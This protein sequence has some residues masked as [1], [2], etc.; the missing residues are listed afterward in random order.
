MKKTIQELEQYKKWNAKHILYKIRTGK[1]RKQKKIDVDYVTEQLQYHM[2]QIHPNPEED[3]V[4]LSKYTPTQSNLSSEVSQCAYRVADLTPYKLYRLCNAGKHIDIYATNYNLK[5]NYRRTS[6]QV[7]SADCLAMDIDYY[8]IP[9][10]RG[11][12]ASDV[13]DSIVNEVLLP[14]GIIPAYGIDSGQGLYIIILLEH[15]NLY[16]NTQNRTMFYFVMNKLLERLNKYGADKSCN[17]IARVF[18][19][20]LTRNSKTCRIAEI[21]N[22]QEISVKE[23]KR[24]DITELYHIFDDNGPIIHSKKKKPDKIKPHNSSSSKFTL[25]SL[26]QA[27][28]NDLLKLLYMRNRCMEHK[29]NIFLFYYALARAEFFTGTISDL[30]KEVLTVNQQLQYPLKSNEVNSTVKS[31]FD[32]VYNRQTHNGKKFYYYSNSDIIKHLEI[33][34]LECHD[35]KTLITPNLKQKRHNENRKKKRRDAAGKTS[36]QRQFEQRLNDIKLLYGQGLTQ[37]EIAHK[38]NVSASLVCQYLKKLNE[39]VS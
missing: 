24:Y 34:D 8:T 12:K 3:V 28:A 14:L 6:S 13:Y 18:R 35:M 29:R 17:D 27:R 11:K 30:Q 32:S 16:N 5:T 31:A 39:L 15:L 33:T 7:V 21:I 23:H 19:L 37:K 36:R 10:L 2:K 38:I 9:T 26:G 25:N 20:P 1:E 4:L 22:F